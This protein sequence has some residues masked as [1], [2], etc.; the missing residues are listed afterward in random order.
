VYS[1]TQHFPLVEKMLEKW[2][3]LTDV[4]QPKIIVKD[5]HTDEG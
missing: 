1:Q 5:L 3:N 4:G 2:P